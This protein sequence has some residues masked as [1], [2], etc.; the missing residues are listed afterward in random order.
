MREIGFEE[1]R[2]TV[3]RGDRYLQFSELLY[4][5]VEQADDV[6]THEEM[7][8]GLTRS[9]EWLVSAENVCQLLRDKLLPLGI[10]APAEGD[11][12]LS[13][14]VERGTAS[15]LRTNGRIKLLEPEAI[16]LVTGMLQVLFSP[17]VL[18]PVLVLMAL[19]HGWLYLEHGMTGAARDVLY[20][21][22]LILVLLAVLFVS[23]VFHEL[24]HAATLRYGGGRIRGMSFGFYLVHPALYTGTTDVYRLGRWA[25]VRTDLVGLWLATGWEFLLV[26]VPIINLNIVYQCLVFVRFDGYWALADLTGIPDFFSQMGAFLRSI[27]LPR[28][29]KGGSLPNLKPWVKVVFAPLHRG[30]G[31]SADATSLLPGHA[32]A[33]H[34]GSRLGFAAHTAREFSYALHIGDFLGM[35]VSVAQ[36]F[37][38]MLQMLGMFYLLYALGQ[39]LIV[40]PWRKSAGHIV[41]SR[42]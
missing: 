14:P 23:G 7:A 18:V 2:W 1:R 17:L 36:A 41:R 15:P 32:A 21:P 20:A 11:A 27:L 28:L 37:V 34:R 26:A 30:H 33:R 40:A 39:T 9:T 5:V 8:E 12:L 25:R 42:R 4:C 29:R 19:V 16:E 6:S 38:I 3:R 35:A 13:A 24:G 10:V 22:G 31:T